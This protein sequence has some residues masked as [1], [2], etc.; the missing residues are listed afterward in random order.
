MNTIGMLLAHVAV[1]EVNLVQVG[2]LAEPAGHVEDVLGIGPDDDG[3][4]LPPAGAPPAVLTGLGLPFYEDLLARAAAH[5]RAALAAIPD[6][7]LDEDVVR[8]PRPDGSRRVFTRRWILFHLLEHAA[9]HLG[10]VQLLVRL[11]PRR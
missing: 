7:A 10:Q 1:A 4:P 8:P 2:L 9:G 11:L 5:T 6:A 3:L